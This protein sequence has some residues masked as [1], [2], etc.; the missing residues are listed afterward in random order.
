MNPPFHLQ[1]LAG[2]QHEGGRAPGE[3]IIA[4]IRGRVDVAVGGGAEPPA[5]LRASDA[6]HIPAACDYLIAALQDS[7]VCVYA[8][9]AEKF[10]T[11]WG[12]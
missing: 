4:V 11:L 6:L 5:H 1:R 3:R 7:E 9:P 12:V 8:P 10:P 2:G